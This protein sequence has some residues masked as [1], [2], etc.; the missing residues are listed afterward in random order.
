MYVYLLT[1]TFIYE[2]TTTTTATTTENNDINNTDHDKIPFKH[3][4]SSKR[5]ELVFV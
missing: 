4:P 1:I 2:S 3:S 5:T